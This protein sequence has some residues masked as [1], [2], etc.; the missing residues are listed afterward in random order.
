L[1]L[2]SKLISSLL[3]LLVYSQAFAINLMAVY[4]SACKREMGAII[5]IKDYK[6]SFLT[7]AG[8]VIS[9]RPHQIIYLA[10]Y[11]IDR[12]PITGTVRVKG[13]P[14]T[15]IETLS[16]GEVA[17]LLEGWP[18]GF[19]K[20]KISFLT[21]NGNENVIDRRNIHS[22][23]LMTKQTSFN[24]YKTKGQSK[25]VFHHPYAFRD[26][27]LPKV[28][29]PTEVYPQQVLSNP[30]MIKRELDVLQRGYQ[31]VRDY[32]HEQQF[33][34]VPEVY[35][36]LTTLGI[37]QNF[38]SRYGSSSGR[39]NNVAPVLMNSYSSDVFDYQHVFITGSHPLFYSGH[40]EAQTQAYYA[41]K[42]SYFHMHMMIDPSLFLVGKKYDWSL[43]DMSSPD[44]KLVDTS[45]I[46]L[47]FD[48]G[49]IALD[50]FMTDIYD[51]GVRV[52]DEFQSAT[53][54]VPHFGLTYR[55]YLFS[56]DGSLGE[57]T[58]EADN[59]QGRDN[60]ST[61]SIARLNL[62]QQFDRFKYILSFIHR[63]VKFDYFNLQYESRSNTLIG[64][65][66]YRWTT[67]Y[68][69]GA[70]LGAESQS[71]QFGSTDLSLSGTDLFFKG[72]I[73][74]SISF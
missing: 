28:S 66:F 39:F 2:Y 36:N 5:D 74:G 27:A 63:R 68:W 41:F 17:T 40:G 14:P 45:T 35:K 54:N 25:L 44:D 3:L 47:G 15:K 72:G 55:N 24:F 33:Y 11:P 4:T 34:A 69:V 52:G 32:D 18:I 50:M 53:I 37:W 13:V 16:H 65:G 51:V 20:D 56:L 26:C 38:G 12:F 19:T 30:I 61:L 29:R 48:F 58:P 21:I 7:T 31:R 9:L 23:E 8:K 71:N 70:Y 49:P 67:R 60:F 57:S 43:R 10:Y 1:N 46:E 62:R 6:V 42:A 22:L 73:Y 64:Y 59:Q